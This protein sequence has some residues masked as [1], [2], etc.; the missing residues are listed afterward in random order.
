MSRCAGGRG[1]WIGWW[2][3]IWIEVRRTKDDVRIT[4]DEFGK[5]GG[6]RPRARVLRGEKCY[7]L[8]KSKESRLFA[9]WKQSSMFAAK[10]SQR[11]N[12]MMWFQELSGIKSMMNDSNMKRMELLVTAFR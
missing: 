5:S 1:G 11:L 4:K 10:S 3:S 6:L 8:S 7:L 2:R 12:V 9:R